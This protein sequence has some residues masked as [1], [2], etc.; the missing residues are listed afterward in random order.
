MF[1]KDKEPGERRSSGTPS[2]LSNGMQVT[3]DIDSDGEV[4]ID[5]I[6]TGDIKCAKL[7]I[8]ESGKVN[9]AVVAD[10]CLVHGEVIGQIRADSVTLSRSSR[11]EGDVLHDT[12]A[13]E[14]GARLEGHCRRFESEDND[15]KLD[16]VV[17]DV[18]KSAF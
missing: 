7:T 8:G 9:G 15:P 16:L 4:Q 13:I 17:T 18:D 2:I 6:L 11:V 3:G 14:P 10:D 5:G 12:L 1:S